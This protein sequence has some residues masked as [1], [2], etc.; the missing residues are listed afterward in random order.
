MFKRHRY[1]KKH[2]FKTY[3]GTPKQILK[4][5]INNCYNNTFFQT[6]NGH[7]CQ[8]YTRDFGWCTESLL[9]LGYK[10]QVTSTLQY[11]LETFQKHNKITVA[12]TPDNIPFNFPNEA[13]DSLPWLIHSLRLLN[14]KQ[15]IDKHKHFLIQQ[16]NHFTSY[17]DKDG[18][19]RRDKHFSSMKDYAKRISS[20]YDNCMVSQ[21]QQD[22][23]TLKLPNP[24]KKYNYKKLI[25]HHFWTGSHFKD[26]LSDN[27]E[28][29]GDANIFPFLTNTIKDKTILKKAIKAIESHNLTSPFPLKYSSDYKK[30]HKLIWLELFAGDYER[31][32]IWLHMGPL[33][34]KL[35]KTTN[36]KE[37]KHHLNTYLSL[38]KKH[39]T[40]L[41]VFDR[42]GH[43]FS[44]KFYTTDEGM[45]WSA[46]LMTLL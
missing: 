17:L 35:L 32:A 44:T 25:L 27:P 5:I 39:K 30:E 41:E 10:K 21:L 28:V 42:H 11:A 15:L 19:V 43:P 16:I 4:N 18:L 22:L 46:N 37:Y 12:I 24:L 34:L 45:L 26:D 23:T 1:V 33:Y 31:D 20:C 29:S 9:K 14:N 6:S 38:I 2:G 36:K 3:K 13:I 8:F 40:F 7:F